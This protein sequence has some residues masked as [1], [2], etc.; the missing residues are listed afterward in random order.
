MALPIFS[1]VIMISFGQYTG[2]LRGFICLGRGSTGASPSRKKNR[3]AIKLSGAR[4]GIRMR[5]KNEDKCVG[6]ELRMSENSKCHE[7]ERRWMRREPF[8]GRF[9]SAFFFHR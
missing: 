6:N 5:K 8:F 4:R 2:F 9:M 1:V 7:A 3:H